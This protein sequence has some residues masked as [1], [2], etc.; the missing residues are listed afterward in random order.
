MPQA[1]EDA[2]HL[3]VTLHADE[4][5]PAQEL[6]LA[7]ADVRAQRAEHAAI[8]AH[9][10]LDALARPA[11]VAILEQR[12]EV[13]A[14]RPAQRILEIDDARPALVVV[15]QDHEVARVEVAMHE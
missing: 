5:E 14:D 9:P 2:E 3:D 7:A 1:A 6:V 11:D 4:I 12:H 10:A 8:A 13:V 15:G